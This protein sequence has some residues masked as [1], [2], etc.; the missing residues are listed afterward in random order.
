[1]PAKS[2]AHDRSA[3]SR[4]GYCR[5]R[6]GLIETRGIESFAEI[7]FALGHSGEQNIY[8]DPAT[9]HLKA[10]DFPRISVDR[11]LST[12]WTYLCF[13]IVGKRIRDV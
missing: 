7:G 4:L 11:M 3:G 6:H 13:I 8:V 2:N 5:S 12:L 1:M 9:H 10:T